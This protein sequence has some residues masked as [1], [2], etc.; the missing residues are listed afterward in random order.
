MNLTKSLA[1]FLLF[2]CEKKN[3]VAPSSSSSFPT[4][5]IYSEVLVFVCLD[6]SIPITL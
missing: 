6:N 3:I 5:L 1:Q 4:K 2:F